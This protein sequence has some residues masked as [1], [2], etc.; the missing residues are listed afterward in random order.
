M[1]LDE[2]ADK[3]IAEAMQRSQA[4]AEA[5]AAREKIDP[6]SE[7]AQDAETYK[8]RRQDVEYKTQSGLIHGRLE[9]TPTHPPTHNRFS[10]H[11]VGS[12]ITHH[13]V[14]FCPFKLRTAN[15]VMHVDSNPLLRSQGGSLHDPEG[16]LICAQDQFL[17][18]KIQNELPVN[19][20]FSLKEVSV[21]I[22]A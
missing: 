9:S 17:S 5:E 7:E 21:W 8:L 18:M 6:D 4:A 16:M 20:G 3:E 14:S 10:L 12:L 11:S 15:A 2:F 13:T 19:I 1:S 22:F